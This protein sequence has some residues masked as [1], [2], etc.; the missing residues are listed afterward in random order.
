MGLFRILL[1]GL[2]IY[3]IYKFI[4][5]LLF[6]SLNGRSQKYTNQGSSK[7]PGDTTVNVPKNESEKKD[8]KKGDYID[9]EEVD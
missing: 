8:N 3:L 9:Y 5:R 1:Y 7:K 4:V 6:P 2:I